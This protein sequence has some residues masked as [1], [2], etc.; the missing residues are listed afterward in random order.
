MVVPNR[1]YMQQH[2]EQCKW[3]SLA[4]I[5][6]SEFRFSVTEFLICIKILGSTNV[7][8]FFSGQYISITCFVLSSLVDIAHFPFSISFIPPWGKSS[9]SCLAS[10]GNWIILMEKIMRFG[11][12]FEENE[13]APYNHT[14]SVLWV[15]NSA[16]FCG[17]YKAWVS[18]DRF[19]SCYQMCGPGFS[20]HIATLI[21]WFEESR[22]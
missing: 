17:H 6:Q 15:W 3:L 2:I 22:A 4:H 5:F 7:N 21:I 12:V 13:R 19:W 9:T 16:L 14:F 18:S 8:R 10:D 1:R 20:N 11:N